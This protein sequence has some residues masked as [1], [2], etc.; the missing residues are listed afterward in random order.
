VE[1][2]EASVSMKEEIKQL[3]QRHLRVEVETDTDYDTWGAH[4]RV[5]VQLWWVDGNERT[6]LSLDSDSLNHGE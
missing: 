3:L 2:E 1:E 4:T 5:E 6:R